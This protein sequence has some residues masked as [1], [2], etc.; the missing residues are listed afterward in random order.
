MT[1]QE[2]L[3]LFTVIKANRIKMKDIAHECDISAPLLSRFFNNQCNMSSENIQLVK[4][5]IARYKDGA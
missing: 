2:R 1:K 3:E 5:F 4:D